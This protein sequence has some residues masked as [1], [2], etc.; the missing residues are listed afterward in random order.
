MSSVWEQD[1]M[2]WENNGENTQSLSPT[3][4]IDLLKG[5]SCLSSAFIHKHIH[6]HK[7][8]CCCARRP[9]TRTRTSPRPS[10]RI[11][12]ALLP[13]KT[14]GVT[15]EDTNRKTDG[16]N[17]AQTEADEE[18]YQWVLV[19]MP[20]N[21]GNQLMISYHDSYSLPIIIRL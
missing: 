19:F 21:V 9:R 2:G 16:R 8:T 15:E 12:I 17:T 6:V 11:R 5:T 20:R 1:A 3:T 10:A 13:P 7:D 14:K 4:L 18:N